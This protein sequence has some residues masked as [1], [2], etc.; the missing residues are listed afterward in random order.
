MNCSYHAAEAF[1]YKIARVEDWLLVLD[2]ENLSLHK[3]PDGQDLK[4]YRQ[5]QQ[6]RLRLMCALYCF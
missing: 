5:P 3:L 6:N 2:A 1:A 4:C